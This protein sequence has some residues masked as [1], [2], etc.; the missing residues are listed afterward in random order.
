MH[1]DD[2][3]G[4]LAHDLSR[5]LERRRFL[6]AL[7]AVGLVPLAACVVADDGELFGA[8][9][10]DASGGDSSTDASSGGDSSSDGGD[11]SGGVSSCEAIP[12]E[13]AGPYPGDGSNGPNAL[14]LSGI[15]RRDIRTS[16][17]TASGVAEGIALTVTLTLVDVADGCAPLAGHAVY[18]W[19]CNRDGDYSMYTGSAA[20]EN[21]LRGVQVTDDDGKVTFT[22]IFPAC[23]SGRWP[24]IHFEIY[25]SL[26]DATDGSDPLHVS[27]LALPEAACDEVF[28]TDGYEDSVGN[29]AQT[30][31]SSDNVFGDGSSLQVAD[32]SGDVDAGYVASLVVGVPT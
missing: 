30:S 15:V 8:S 12:T 13:T 19:H 25:A 23:Y 9:T 32:V 14:E 2:H 17:D 1:D 3:H 31:L 26:E 20:S 6:R 10:D 24:H 7:G 18:L 28:A 22:T 4:G 21:Y 5:L 29:L 16:V 27:Q 11:S